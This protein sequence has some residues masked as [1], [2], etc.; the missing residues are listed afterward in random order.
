ME[1]TGPE[2][3]RGSQD[4]ARSL[5]QWRD[6]QWLAL[7]LIKSFNDDAIGA[8]D[9]VDRTAL[10]LTA[11]QV[12]KD[13]FGFSACVYISTFDKSQTADLIS[14]DP[15]PALIG[16]YKALAH[17]GKARRALR[18]FPPRPREL[19]GVEGHLL[20]APVDFKTP[21]GHHFA[22]LLPYEDTWS[23]MR[24][25][26]MEFV[27]DQIHGHFEALL[28]AE[29]A[30]E[31][32]IALTASVVEKEQQL[33]FKSAYDQ[34]T[35]LMTRET[36]LN[37]TDELIARGDPLCVVALGLRGYARV[38]HR[39]GYSAADGLLRDIARRLDSA[40]IRRQSEVLLGRLADDRFALVISCP[41]SVDTEGLTAQVDQLC[42][43]L[44]VGLKVSNEAISLTAHAGLV[45]VPEDAESARNAVNAA[46]LAL[47]AVDH[48]VGVNVM[49]FADLGPGDRQDDSLLLETEINASLAKDHFQLWYQPKVNMATEA[50]VGAE[51]LMRW[52]HP[53][54]GRVSP[55]QFIPAAERSGQIIELGELALRQACKQVALWRS[56]GFDPGLVSVNLSPVQV[57]SLDLPERFQQILLEERLPA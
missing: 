7:D 19:P 4:V 2:G 32:T 50:I 47:D 23:G 57:A 15:N 53:S 54:L 14:D 28:R 35:G 36:L 25:R 37:A 33:E 51:A 52:N 24:G 6:Q 44:G 12:L 22:A 10:A 42:T 3:I 45:R 31:R 48:A 56:Q 8:V 40:S 13:L 29:R 49:V 9:A 1:L 38:H 11:V 34:V 39:Y 41:N 17:S 46:E 26:M 5:D 27:L 20:V 55:V 18:E 16:A 30:R 43:T 21:L